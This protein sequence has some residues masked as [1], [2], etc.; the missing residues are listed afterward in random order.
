MAFDAER[1]IR[2]AA[3]GVAFAILWLV[4]A[5]ALFRL[6][7]PWLWGLPSAAAP[8]AAVAGVLLGVVGLM[9]LALI[10]IRSFRRRL[11]ERRE[12]KDQ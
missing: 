5:F 11:T 2:L 9:Y 10:M 4:C 1:E 6:I 8:V 12:G 7:T 3:R